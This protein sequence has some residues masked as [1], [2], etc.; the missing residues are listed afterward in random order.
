[1]STEYQ[2]L[3]ESGKGFKSRRKRVSGLDP[4][5]AKERAREKTRRYMEAKRR[6]AHVLAIRY[7]DEYQRLLAEELEGVHAERG[8]LPGDP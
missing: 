4:A 6:A 5:V 2:K 3:A 8:P 7:E 1:M